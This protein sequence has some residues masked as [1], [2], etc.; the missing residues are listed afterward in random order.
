MQ[1]KF[2]EGKPVS[3]PQVLGLSAS[4]GIGAKNTNCNDEKARQHILE[5]CAN[6]DAHCLQV[7]EDDRQS[8]NTKFLPIP[9][10]GISEFKNYIKGV[11]EEIENHLLFVLEGARGSGSL[12]RGSQS[13]ENWVVEICKRSLGRDLVTCAEH[14]REYN[15]VLMISEDLRTEDALSYLKETIKSKEET[16]VELWLRNL[17]ENTRESFSRQESHE[18]NAWLEK[19]EELL[20]EKF[21]VGSNNNTSRVIIFSRTRFVAVA[22]VDW[23]KSLEKLKDVIRPT[24]VIG[25]SHRNGKG[26]KEDITMHWATF[27]ML[28]A[29]SF[30]KRLRDPLKVNV[31]V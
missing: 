7:L 25:C 5:I 22:L 20:L 1:E 29:H 30:L 18:T 31:T 13:Y 11:M 9:R 4:L 17:Y 14:L 28:R 23:M 12:R 15:N 2:S 3:L 6:L 21:P 16:E 10:E 19:V 24:Y 27:Q 26:K 8:T